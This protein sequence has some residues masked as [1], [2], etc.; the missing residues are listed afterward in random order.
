MRFKNDLEKKCFEAAK[1]ALGPHVLIEHNKTITIENALFRE[2]ASFKGPP[3]KEIDVLTAK[4]LDDPNV[5]L[6]VSCKMLSRR[7][8]PAHIQ[9]WAAVI[10]TMN[11]Y[12]DGTTYFGLVLSPTGFTSGSEPWATSHNLGL[13]PPL[14]GRML[15]F[16]E[17][18]VL[19]MLERVLKAF[20]VRAR[21]RIDDLVESPSFYDFVYRL[22][23][24]Y[25]GH[26]EANF[27]ARYCFVPQNWPS[28]FGEMYSA[29][30]GRK[31]EEVV[32]VQGA[33]ALRLSGGIVLRFESDRIAVGPDPTAASGTPVEPQCWKNLDMQ[34]CTMDF[35]EKLV[36]GRA[37]SSAGDFGN[38]IEFGLD[39]C[40]NFGLHVA[41]FHLISTEG[42]AD[43]NRL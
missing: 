14:K 13:L 39:K 33:T 8:E 6:L 37:I 20:Q 30:V 40:L 23:A 26:Q 38:Y 11:R 5:V 3:K 42:L 21:I 41:G 2:V 4:I 1:R 32:A 31:V 7:A 27:D 43:E 16:N 35:I 22:S 15:S 28:S 24:D 9:E 12:S 17:D 10:Q 19:R 18:T 36:V 25:E 34:T 29:V